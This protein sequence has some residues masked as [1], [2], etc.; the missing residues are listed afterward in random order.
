MEDFGHETLLLVEDEAIIALA[1]QSI[2]K[3]NGYEVF[4]AGSGSSA[5]EA[6]ED[7]RSLIDLVLMDIDL[8][9]GMDG[10]QAAEII[11]NSANIPVLFL[12]SHTEKEVVLKTEGI[13]SLGYVL[14]N[15]GET[16]LLASIR[17]ALRLQESKLQNQRKMKEL[18]AANEALR[19]SEAEFRG[20]FETGPLAVGMLVG[21]KF[22]NVNEVMCRTFGYAKA[23]M[24]G[25]TTRMLY[26]DDA[27]YRRVGFE[28]YRD[29]RLH[30]RA[31]IETRLRK[32]DGAVL[33][34]LVFARP[35]DPNAP[36]SDMG[37]ATTILDIT[38]RLR[39]QAELARFREGQAEERSE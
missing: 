7:H 18:A 19:R 36:D 4:I 31:D 24:L 28:L 34:V 37:V 8:G 5:I 23:E 12:S 11:M 21:R 30:G 22:V 9:K 13:D 27:E 25:N 20:L 35:L 29:L 14:K 2:L 10:T 17:M 38:D 33:D 39:L 16:V 6:A 15:S 1:E 26:E 3:R 32:K